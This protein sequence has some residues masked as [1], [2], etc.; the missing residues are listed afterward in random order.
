VNSMKNVLLVGMLLVVGYAVC[1]SLYRKS[2]STPA[3]LANQEPAGPP[4]VEGMPSLAE[5]APSSTRP[6]SIA[7]AP[8][9]GGMAPTF[10]PP[11]GT[12]PSMGLGGTPSAAG[13]GMAPSFAPPSTAPGAP[14]GLAGGPPPSP[15]SNAGGGTAPLFGEPPGKSGPPGGLFAAPSPPP[16]APSAPPSAPLAPPST[17]SFAP[18]AAPPASATPMKGAAE[19]TDP[20][21][22]KPRD[23]A[24]AV[25]PV[26]FNAGDLSP[27]KAQAVLAEARALLDQN[28]WADAHLRLS[29]LYDNPQIPPQEARGIVQILDDLAARVVYSRQHLLEGAY[30]VQWGDTLERIATGYSVPPQLLAK[31][32]G[33]ADP[34]NLP[35]G[36]EL[37][38][39]RGPFNAIIN[40]GR[41]ELT[42]MVNGRYAGRFRIGIG[43]DS[44]K[45]EGNYVVRE[46][47]TQVPY[48]YADRS[49][50]PEK[51]QTPNQIFILDLGNGVSIHGTTDARG[52]GR[53]GNQGS[54]C[55][56]QPDIDDVFG[57]LSVGSKVVIKR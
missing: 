5:S 21:A 34:Q 15:P 38:V 4:K 57:I 52:I 11:A 31:I 43:T 29:A 56:G 47:R 41:F 35:P 3:S 7:S 16:A 27:D 48:A 51:S 19:L 39:L 17:T 12:P 22:P 2:P 33:L 54:I 25:T 36:T 20:F 6:G 13:S 30:Q 24:G 44:A 32:N 53:A 28:R 46:K 10:S 55:L 18:L 45:L 23:A 42:L 26:V 9:G 14:A 1:V 37:K 49:V 40:L 50:V 8:D